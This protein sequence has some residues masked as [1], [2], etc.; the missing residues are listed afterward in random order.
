M[1]QAESSL[2]ETH[3]AMQELGL[4]INELKARGDTKVDIKLCENLID[5]NLELIDAL[6]LSIAITEYDNHRR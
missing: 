4:K 6:R 1:I 2:N 3:E 5:I